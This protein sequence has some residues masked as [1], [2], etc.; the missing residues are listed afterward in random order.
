[1]IG[2]WCAIDLLQDNS[3]VSGG[4]GHN[5]S[6]ADQANQNLRWQK[7]QAGWWKCNVD[8]SFSQTQNVVA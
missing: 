8:A 2:E 7:P 1:M 3:V 4:T 5:T 6:R